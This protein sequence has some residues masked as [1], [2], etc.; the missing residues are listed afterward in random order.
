MFNK[1]S[2]NVLLKSVIAVLAMVVIVMLS[3]SASKS[4]TRLTT[5]KRISIAADASTDLF[6]ALH[7]LRV[8]RSYTTR[9]LNSEKQFTEVYPALKAMR[10]A[11]LPALKS[12]LTKLE[13]ADFPERQIVLIVEGYVR[14]VQRR[15]EQRGLA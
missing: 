12:A 2:V 8:D 3:F 10:D 4:W 7:N 14:R 1:I 11:D 15:I 5:V 6:T 13:S 9:D